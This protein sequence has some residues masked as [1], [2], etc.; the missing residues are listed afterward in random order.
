MLAIHGYQG[1]PTVTAALKIGSLLP[2][3]PGEIRH[4]E[5]A[6]VDFEAATWSIPAD[7]MNAG[8]S[9]PRIAIK[10]ATKSLR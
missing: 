1:S 10:S 3:R 8:H 4:M 2:A 9:V 7:K 5:W 6:E